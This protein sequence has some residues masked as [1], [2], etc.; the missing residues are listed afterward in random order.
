MSAVNPDHH[1]HHNPMHSFDATVE[2]RLGTDMRLLYGMGVPVIGMCVIIAVALGF[3]A[4]AWVVA[5]LMVLE[6]VVLG[7]VLVGFTG[8]LNEDQSERE[9]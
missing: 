9:Q 8:M 5:G 1:P 6:A 2:R 7:V 4:S 3:A